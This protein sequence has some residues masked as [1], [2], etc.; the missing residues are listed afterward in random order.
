VRDVLVQRL[1]QSQPGQLGKITGWPRR[2]ST[3]RCFTAI[4]I[5]N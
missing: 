2:V 3:L 5:I 1:N 4:T